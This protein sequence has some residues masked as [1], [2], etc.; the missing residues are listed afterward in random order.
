MSR[1]TCGAETQGADRVSSQL[2]LK[3]TAALD[4][5]LHRP[6]SAASR[7]SHSPA[8]Q[9]LGV[10]IVSVRPSVCYPIRALRLYA[11]L[12]TSQRTQRSRRF[13]RNSG[14]ADKTWALIFAPQQRIIR[15]HPGEHS[16]FPS[17]SAKRSPSK[18]SLRSAGQGRGRA[19]RPV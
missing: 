10:T 15:V 6:L 1:N 2:S 8:M 12:A 14:T 18:Q 13:K 3:A 16:C 4:G 11:R 19:R 5:K 9:T 7:V 17:R